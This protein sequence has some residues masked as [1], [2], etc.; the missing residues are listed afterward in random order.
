MLIKKRIKQ[1]KYLA[2]AISMVLGSAT[3]DQASASL[4]SLGAQDF[5]G[6]GLG[7]VNTILTIQNRG[8]EKGCV[9]RSTVGCPTGTTNASGDVIGGTSGGDEKTGASQTLTRTISD[10]GLT[11]AAALRIVFNAVEPA[12]DS[13]T[14]E[15][16]VLA[17]YDTS[18]ALVFSSGPFTPETFP[19]TNPGTGNAGFVFALDSSQASAAQGF[20]SG[21][22]RIGLLAEASA[23]AG[24]NETFFVVNAPVP[25]PGTL[26]LIGSGLV[27]IGAGAWRRKKS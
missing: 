16:L 6:T 8:T 19:D 12:G 2:L 11:S 17:I 14:L 13:I 21:G 3:L 20:F 1:V 5:Q 4:V 7:A 24:G 27:G 18:D 15:N 22:F 25:E 9:G 26:L 10:L 23:A